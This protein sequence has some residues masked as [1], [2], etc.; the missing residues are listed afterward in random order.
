MINPATANLVAADQMDAER[1]F[2]RRAD[3]ADL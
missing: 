2:D 3:L 1:R